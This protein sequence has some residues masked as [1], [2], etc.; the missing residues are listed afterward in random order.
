MTATENDDG[1]G[2]AHNKNDDGDGGAH[3]KNYD[4]D[5]DADDEM[6]MVMSI[7]IEK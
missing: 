1:D 6:I 2:G 7:Q 5:G 4:G 3:D